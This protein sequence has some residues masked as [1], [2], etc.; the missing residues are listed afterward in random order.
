MLLGLGGAGRGSPWPAVFPSLSLPRQQVVLCLS[1][2]CVCVHAASMP[3]FGLVIGVGRPVLLSL[4][5]GAMMLR[6][7][8]RQRRCA[9]IAVP[10]SVFQR[11]KRCS[12]ELPHTWQLTIS[13]TLIEKIISPGLMHLER[14][15]GGPCSSAEPHRAAARQRARSPCGRPARCWWHRAL[16]LVVVVASLAILAEYARAEP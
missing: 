4:G 8:A 1:V 11:C 16:P 3:P 12:F 5:G 9:G 2:W 15:G 14:A 6:A 13:T 7:D 10:F